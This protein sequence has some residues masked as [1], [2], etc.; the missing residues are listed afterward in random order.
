[1]KLPAPDTCIIGYLC[2]NRFIWKRV[3]PNYFFDDKIVSVLPND[4]MGEG[5]LR[6]WKICDQEGFNVQDTKSEGACS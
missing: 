3:L 4:G 5:P 1:M 2:Y 6:H